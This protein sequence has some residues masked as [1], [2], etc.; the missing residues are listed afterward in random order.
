MMGSNIRQG[1]EIIYNLDYFFEMYLENPRT[2]G[3]A[4]FRCKVVVCIN[5]NI[6]VINVVLPTD[7]KF[8]D[9]AYDLRR[10][11]QETNGSWNLAVI[12]DERLIA[13]C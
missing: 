13:R 5:S 4:T 9:K 1:Q 8:S 11:F 3:D 12:I 7:I 10:C 6:M 2:N